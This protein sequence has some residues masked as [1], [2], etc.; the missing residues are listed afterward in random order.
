M[1]NNLTPGQLERLAYLAEECAE[2]IQIVGKIIRHGYYSSNPDALTS[3]NNQLLLQ[4][5]LM[6]VLQ[7]M[8]RMKNNDDVHIPIKE[9]SYY[10]N[11]Y[12][13]HQSEQQIS[14]EPI[15]NSWS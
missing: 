4:D 13:H 10:N 12:W 2:V 1:Y 15:I 6:N 11:Q 3:K 5:E 9:T 7:A 8:T 14:I